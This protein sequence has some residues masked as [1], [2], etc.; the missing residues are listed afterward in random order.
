MDAGVAGQVIA[1]L[2]RQLMGAGQIGI[3]QHGDEL[4]AAEAGEQITR[5]QAL[6]Q[7]LGGM[8]QAGVAGQMAILVVDLLE[9]VEVHHQD[10]RGAL[11]AHGLGLGAVQLFVEGLAVEQAGKAVPTVTFGQLPVGAG[12]LAQGL[13]QSRGTLCDAQFQAVIDLSLQFQALGLL[14]A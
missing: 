1:Q 14:H 7:T 4:F 12:K 3:A 13:L 8:L 10:G 2:F 6:L 5:P 9:M 11:A